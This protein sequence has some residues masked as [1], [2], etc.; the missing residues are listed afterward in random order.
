MSSENDSLS[1]ASPVR[2]NTT[3]AGDEPLIVDAIPDIDMGQFGVLFAV[4][5]LATLTLRQPDT[6]G[7]P[8]NSGL[9]LCPPGTTVETLAQAQA[10]LNLD[11]RP[12][13][14]PLEDPYLDVATIGAVPTYSLRMASQPGLK[15]P[16]PFGWFIRAI[17]V[18]QQGSATP[19]PGANSQGRI[20]ALISVESKCPCP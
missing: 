1:N 2:G 9:Y 3:T 6:R 13:I 19:G 20:Q 8:P 5:F 12:F 10:G 15:L 4:S 18:C 7:L 16:V 14:I 17:V 11:A